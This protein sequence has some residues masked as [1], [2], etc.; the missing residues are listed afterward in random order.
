MNIPFALPYMGAEEI[1]AAASVIE[2]GWLTSGPKVAEFETEFAKACGEGCHAVA[3]SSCTIGLTLAILARVQ[4]N[5]CGIICPTWTFTATAEA[6]EAAGH[7]P[8]FVD[9][10]P[11]TLTFDLMDCDFLPQHDAV[12]PVHIAGRR[13]AYRAVY[14]AKAKPIIEDAAH[15][16]PY[17][18]GENIAVFSFYATKPIACGEGGMVVTRSEHYAEKIRAMRWHG[19]DQ[20]VHDRHRTGYRAHQVTGRGFKANMTDLQAALGLEQLKRREASHHLRG[21]L[22][23]RYRRLLRGCMLPPKQGDEGSEHLFIIRVPDRDTFIAK[24]HERGIACGVHYLP[25]HRHKYWAD[26]YG[27]K[28]EHFPNAEAAN[29]HAVSLPLWAGMTEEQQDR[30]IEAARD[31]LT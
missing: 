18:P 17:D 21:C 8:I 4:R 13:A 29:R 23:D 3:V 7:K 16:L 24:M 19:I 22:V 9:I 12:I 27:L 28:P 5:C 26:K 20:E 11:E 31:I 30:V 6:I 10:N 2:S 14:P 1:R 15:C 25:L